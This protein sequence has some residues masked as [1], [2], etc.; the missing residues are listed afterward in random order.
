MKEVGWNPDR[1][2]MNENSIYI[3]AQGCQMVFCYA[4]VFYI[5]YYLGVQKRSTKSSSG[6]K[7]SSEQNS[8]WGNS[9][10]N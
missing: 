7:S 9:K 2:V 3:M 8:T 4:N 1:T 5:G 10:I 6:K